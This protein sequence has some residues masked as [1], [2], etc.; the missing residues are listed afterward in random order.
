MKMIKDLAAGI[1]LLEHTQRG[2]LEILILVDGDGLVVYDYWKL[3][4]FTG[5]KPERIVGK[6]Y[7]YL[8][9][10]MAALS[11]DPY[12]TELEFEQALKG[13]EDY[14]KD[15]T[16]YLLIAN[17]SAERLQIRFFRVGQERLP[18]KAFQWGVIIRDVSRESEEITQQANYL[19]LLTR[20]LRVSLSEI[21]GSVSSL[22]NGHQNWEAEE[23]QYFLESV[24]EGVDQLSQLL[25]NANALSRLESGE[26]KL[27]RHPT[28]IKPLIQQAIRN[29]GLRTT[30]YQFGFAIPDDLPM[31]EIDPQAGERVLRNILSSS[32]KRC[33]PETTIQIGAQLEADEVVISI[34]N[35]GLP[36]ADQQLQHLFEPFFHLGMNNTNRALGNGLELYVA[37]RFT[38]A[39]GGRL[40]SENRTQLGNTLHCAFPLK[41]HSSAPVTLPRP[42]LDGGSKA[43]LKTRTRRSYVRV[44]LVEDDLQ[45]SQYLTAVLERARHQVVVARTGRQ[46]LE[47]AAD[48]PPEIIL[49]DLYLP[50]M[51]GLAVCAQLR[52]ILSV[53]IIMVTANST[54]ETT[55]RALDLGVDDYLTK[56]VDPD[57]L[58]ARIRAVLRRA[59][60]GIIGQNTPPI[61]IEEL[62]IDGNLR[63]ISIRGKA[64]KLTPT[65][66]KLLH[67]LALNAGRVLSHSQILTAVW[68]PQYGQE[69]EYLWVH[70]NRLRR[71]LEHDP[72][73]PHYILTEPSV[74]YYLPPSTDSVV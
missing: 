3:E 51:D 61:Q 73:N 72:A 29:L 19:S 13:L 58:L 31:I 22:L 38:L 42:V 62:R 7:S 23:R 70:I 36:I 34:D 25:E 45:I 15:P 11:A 12:Q 9:N 35:A 21:S 57:E 20:E 63:Q 10:Q 50:D 40:W 16:T 53:P 47:M 1:E 2:E 39:H 71:K 64:V 37:Q 69:K 54:R 43:P 4:Q 67:V 17:R 18:N 44:L 26:I 8:F 5:L 49:L 66:F 27:D 46:A 6:P 55:R 60:G 52:E 59:S 14:E 41:A 56:P 32:I 24:Y 28:A 48:K 30:G 68:G 65:E 33:P 74:G